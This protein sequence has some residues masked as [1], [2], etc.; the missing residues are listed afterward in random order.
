MK[1]KKEITLQRVTVYVL[2]GILFAFAGSVAGVVLLRAIDKLYPN[3]NNAWIN[4][5][6]KEVRL[7]NF[8]EIDSPHKTIQIDWTEQYPFEAEDVTRVMP[9]SAVRLSSLKTA[10]AFAGRIQYGLSRYTGEN[11]LFLERYVEAAMTAEKNLGLGFMKNTVFTSFAI[12]D[13]DY[14]VSY[15]DTADVTAR[16][17]SLA[18]FNQFLQGKNISLLYIQA[19]DKVCEEDAI[20]STRNFANRNA[21]D[22]LAALKQADVPTLDLREEIHRQGLVHHD[23]FLKTDHHWKPETGLWAAKVIADRLNASFGFNIDTSIYSPENYD[24][25]IEDN[26]LGSVGRRATLAA[27]TPEP[28]TF[29]FP[30]FKT[31]LT[32]RIPS[33]NLDERGDFSVIYYKEFWEYMREE[34]NAY[35]KNYYP[36]YFYGNNGLTFVRNEQ[37]ACEKKILMLSDSFNRVMSPFLALGVEKMCVLDRRSFTGSVRSLIDQTSPDI[38]LVLHYPGSISGGIN[39][40]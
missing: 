24:Y 40:L 18:E 22:M 28:I 5:V 8:S 12:L 6:L 14:M 19:P 27:A 13:D 26:N 3:L 29:I 38:V 39:Y 17:N 15:A 23:L 36:I 7:K 1:N 4:V 9:R 30:K 20:A 10:A 16:A 37:A 25:Q 11:L 2:V 21:D 34:K 35:N 33:R 31:D 32:I